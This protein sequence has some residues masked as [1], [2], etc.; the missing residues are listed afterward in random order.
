MPNRLRP[1]VPLLVELG[2]PPAGNDLVPVGAT[3][4]LVV[5]LKDNGRGVVTHAAVGPLDATVPLV[6]PVDPASAPEVHTTR[7]VVVRGMRMW[8]ARHRHLT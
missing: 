6:V 5:Q 7:I 3:G 4:S 1:G 8:Y 2:I